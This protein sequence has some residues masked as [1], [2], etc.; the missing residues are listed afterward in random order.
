MEACC[1]VQHTQ[2]VVRSFL[3]KK[4]ILHF[5]FHSS[6]SKSLKEYTTE[7]FELG[8]RVEVLKSMQ[9]EPMTVTPLQEGDDPDMDAVVSFRNQI[10]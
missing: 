1:D 8:T 3:K 4:V 2:S 6:P 5:H 7:G 10:V 9:E